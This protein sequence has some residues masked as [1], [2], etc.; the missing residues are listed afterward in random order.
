LFLD[1]D[2]EPDPAILFEHDRSHREGADAVLGHIP[3]HP[4]SPNTFL[5]RGLQQSMERRCAR[6]SAP[7]AALSL[8][9]L[10]TGQLSVKRTLFTEVG[11]FDGQ[12]TRDGSFG[13]E[14][15]DF[16][17]R[18]L[19]GGRRIV[20]NPR[21][22]SRQ[23]YVVGVAAHFT[24]WAEVGRADVEFARKHPHMAD[25]LFTLHQRDRRLNRQVIRPLA[26]MPGVSTVAARVGA[27]FVV[28]LARVRPDSPR[29]DNCFRHVRSLHYWRG[30]RAAG[31][32]PSPRPVRVLAYHAISETKGQDV[33]S[34]YV[35]APNRL[36][37]HLSIL[38]WLG[39]RFISGGELR[40]LLKDGAGVPRRAVLLTFDDGYDDLGG[41]TLALLRE[42]RAQAVAFVVTSLV[43][44][45]NVWDQA[46]GAAPRQLASA[47]MLRQL[48]R[49]GVEIGSHS[50]TH[51]SLPS[52]DDTS[53]RTEID[54]SIVGLTAMEL[55][56]PAAFAYPYGEHSESVRA[57]VARAGFAIAFSLEPGCAAP[58]GDPYRIPRN[59]IVARDGTW[60]FL[61]KLWRMRPVTR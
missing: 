41:A 27:W 9:D 34:D 7:F 61:W 29:L 39:F 37:R 17:Q 11:G 25:S 50:C 31:D 36:R 43:G 26:A 3:V 14:D 2:M 10:L 55:P 42:F 53:L 46:V 45:S 1:D 16:G 44:K 56:H 58:S 60:R 24:R 51:P 28:A 48:T 35:V 15:L 8:F 54:A 5:S 21:A 23:R 33:A 18:L 12:F 38:R 20:F 57:A 22:I 19:S 30:V 4:E 40:R 59:E 47:E 6:L 32:M 49:A 52:L 13:D